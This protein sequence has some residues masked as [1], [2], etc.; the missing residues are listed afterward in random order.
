[1]VVLLCGPKKKRPP[2]TT[3]DMLI[4]QAYGTMR[5]TGKHLKRMH[6]IKQFFGLAAFRRQRQLVALGT[7]KL[8]LNK[9]F[10][11]SIRSL[12]VHRSR[13]VSRD[14]TAEGSLESPGV[15]YY[16]HSL[17]LELVYIAGV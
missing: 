17:R 2:M 7:L 11:A 9:S 10:A 16:V 8:L 12:N 3:R 15:N 1:M 6:A 4:P 14:G 13:G 5:E